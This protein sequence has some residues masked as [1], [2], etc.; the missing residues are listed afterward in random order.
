MFSSPSFSEWTR[1]GSNESGDKFH[2]DLAR[3]E[4]DNGYK[5]YWTLSDFARPN[6]RGILSSM[7]GYKGDCNSFRYKLIYAS[8]HRQS[9]GMGN[10]VSGNVN[11][12]WRYAPPNSLNEFYLKTVCN[13]KK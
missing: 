12:E 4:N 7:V 11:G 1:I 3:I 6:S 5:L 2:L 9:M 10:G 8:H 13:Y